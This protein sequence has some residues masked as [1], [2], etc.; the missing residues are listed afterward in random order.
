MPSKDALQRL[1]DGLQMFIREHLALA[2][3]EM[4]ADLRAMGRDLAVTAAGV[5]ALVA[6]YLLLMFA[7]AY[8]L[9]L[10]MPFWAAFAIVALVNLAAGAA[11]TAAGIRRV[12]G[13]RVELPCTTEEIRRDRQ[14]LAAL[15]Q[16]ARRQDGPLPSSRASALAHSGAVPPAAQ[17]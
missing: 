4:K 8:L 14:W 11:L 17:Q 10:L 12:M 6:G 15:K 3:S 9:A 2:R 5:P 7:I 1:L 16:N 13:D